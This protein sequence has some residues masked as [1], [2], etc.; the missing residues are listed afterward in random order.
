M[1]LPITHHQNGTRNDS[2]KARC[3][4][5]SGPLEDYETRTMLICRFSA[6]YSNRSSS[7]PT[8]SQGQI[9]V[10][11][12]RTHRL[13]KLEQCHERSYTKRIT[14]RLRTSF[15]EVVSL[16]ICDTLAGAQI[17][18][19]NMLNKLRDG[20]RAGHGKQGATRREP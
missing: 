16:K 1:L 3:T 19:N 9:A 2:H 17:R 13:L 20:R 15:L 4:T 5:L 12:Q 6:W 11:R 14:M 10:Q 7:S 18:P 8:K